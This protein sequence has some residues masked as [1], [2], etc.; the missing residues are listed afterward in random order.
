MEVNFVSLFQT[1]PFLLDTCLWVH[2]YYLRGLYM[3]CK[4]FRSLFDDNRCSF[5]YLLKYGHITNNKIGSYNKV[6]FNHVIKFSSLMSPILE[7]KRRVPCIILYYHCLKYNYGNPNDFLPK[8][9]NT[10]DYALL[11]FEYNRQDLLTYIYNNTSKGSKNQ[12]AASCLLEKWK[13]F[14]DIEYDL[15]SFYRIYSALAGNAYLS[16]SNI[17][18]IIF[19]LYYKCNPDNREPLLA[20][21]GNSSKRTHFL[22][23]YINHTLEFP[24]LREIAEDTGYIGDLHKL[25]DIELDNYYFPDPSRL[26]EGIDSSF[27]TARTKI[28]V[29]LLGENILKLK[30]L[31]NRVIWSNAD[32]IPIEDIHKGYVFNKCIR[33][34]LQLLWEL[35]H[36]GGKFKKTNKYKPMDP[37]FKEISKHNKIRF[38]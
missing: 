10:V 36:P 5:K 11:A 33:Y 20:L 32:I 14:K 30:E 17:V 23:E 31:R 16:I 18:T 34:D 2:P 21:T 25:K 26:I 3:S 37:F 35:D 13:S 19:R 24:T 7:V 9:I 28:G 15:N 38:T 12:I 4:Y 29:H 8:S 22:E 27:N 1:I 6:K